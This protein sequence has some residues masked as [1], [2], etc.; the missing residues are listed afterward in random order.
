MLM[1]ESARA[2]GFAYR[3][4]VEAR[5]KLAVVLG[6]WVHFGPGLLLNLLV[7]WDLFTTIRMTTLQ[8]RGQSSLPNRLKKAGWPPR[9]NGALACPEGGKPALRSAPILETLA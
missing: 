9:R 3:R 2:V 8:I 6:I 1:P 7:L 5:P 4:A